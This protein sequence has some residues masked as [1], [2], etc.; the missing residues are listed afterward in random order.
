[1]LCRMNWSQ[2][3]MN[4]E[5]QVLETSRIGDPVRF[6]PDLMVYPEGIHYANL[7]VDDIP[8][9]V[10]EHFLKGRVVQKFVAEEVIFTDEELG[11]PKGKEIRSVLRNCGKI[12]PEQ[13]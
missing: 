7:T 1:M 13:H 4:E 2:Q 6:G 10:E 12:D 8:F 9:L 3:G 11:M 5:V